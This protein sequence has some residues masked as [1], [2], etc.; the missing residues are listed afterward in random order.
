MKTSTKKYYRSMV[1]MILAAVSTA[2]FAIDNQLGTA[3]GHAESAA[4][5]DDVKEIETHAESAKTNIT[6]LEQHLKEALNCL[7]SAIE[8]SKHGHVE[9]A[10][11]SAEDAVKH[12]KAAK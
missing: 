9:L 7:N 8:H 2:S 6:N 1:A 5:T 4:K 10:K 11:K 3:L 12:L